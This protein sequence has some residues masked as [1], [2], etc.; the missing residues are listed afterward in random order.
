MA[1]ETRET[2]AQFLTRVPV[3]AEVE[4]ADSNPHMHD[5]GNR[6]RMSHWKI[7]LTLRRRAMTVYFSQGSAHTAEPTVKDVIG[8]LA[9]DAAGYANAR[10]FEDWCGEYGYDTDSRKAERTFKIIGKQADALRRLL[11][12]DHDRLLWHTESE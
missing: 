3:R 11:A 10:S 1:T 8:C 4:W 2:L 7:R 12:D 5:D 9:L 6:D